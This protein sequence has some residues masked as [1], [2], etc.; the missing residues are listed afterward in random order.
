[1]L[2][3]LYYCYHS[4]VHD[5]LKISS[6]HAVVGVSADAFVNDVAEALMLLVF[7]IFLASLL[8]LSSLGFP[9]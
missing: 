3:V 2:L 8:L 5:V 9:W 4:A 1:M 6:V 7:L